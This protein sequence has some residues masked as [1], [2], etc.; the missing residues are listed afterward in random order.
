MTKRKKS[1]GGPTAAIGGMLAGSLVALALLS[2]A[3][4][5]EA[6]DLSRIPRPLTELLAYL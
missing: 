3:L 4:L 2:L 6:L 1:S 5:A